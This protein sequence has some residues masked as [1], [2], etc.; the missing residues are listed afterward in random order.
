V[1]CAKHNEETAVS[2]GRCEAPVCM[3]CMVHSD[4]GVRCRSCAPAR[5]SGPSAPAVLLYC[6]GGVPGDPG[7]RLHRRPGRLGSYDQGTT[8]MATIG[9]HCRSL[10]GGSVAAADGDLEASPR[11]RPVAIDVFV[12][13]S[14]AGRLPPG[15]DLADDRSS[16]TVRWIRGKAAIRRLSPR[17]GRE[18]LGLGTLRWRSNGQSF[19]YDRS[20]VTGDVS[21]VP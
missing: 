12:G 21:R 6:G 19:P 2:C 7:D 3:R 8:T 16:P 1:R 20:C 11:Y 17:A 15:A 9:P 14:N 10:S 13:V 4:V 18:G 5:M